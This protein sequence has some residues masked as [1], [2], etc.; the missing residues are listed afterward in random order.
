VRDVRT[1]PKANLHLHL[2]GSA[3][4]DTIAELADAAGRD[5]RDF[6]VFDG[7]D[8]L[9]AAYVDT[10]ACITSL[11]AADRDRRVAPPRNE[12]VTLRRA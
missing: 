12:H 8:G 4:P 10:M 9:Q 3:R 11:D 1:L 2:E 5:P 7:W 6:S